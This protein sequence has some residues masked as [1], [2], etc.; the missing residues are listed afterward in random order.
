MYAFT[1]R[2]FILDDPV[3]PSLWNRCP[4]FQAFPNNIAV[5][6]G[7]YYFIRIVQDLQRKV[8][9][10][11][12]A[13]NTKVVIDSVSIWGDRGG[14][15][16]NT[17]VF[18]FLEQGWM[19]PGSQDKQEAEANKPRNAKPVFHFLKQGDPDIMRKNFNYLYQ[20]YGW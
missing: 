7:I 11:T 9:K 19:S 18:H 15:V 6:C 2:K 4:I 17:G 10:F 12:V 13:L 14:Y 5:A 3:I 1:V 20:G 16:G 8:F